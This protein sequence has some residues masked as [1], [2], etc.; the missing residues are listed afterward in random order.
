M[1]AHAL[2]RRQALLSAG[3]L[4]ALGAAG[5]AGRTS[6]LAPVEASYPRLQ[7]LIDR[8]V[9]EGRLAG[10]TL[11]VKTRGAAL[12]YQT[13]GRLALDA[14]ARADADSLYR[15]YSMTKPVTGLAAMILIEEGRLRL[16]Q[17]IS[18][19]LPDFRA[20]RVLTDAASGATR[21]AENAITVRHLLTHTS[22]LS[23]NINAGDPV[24]ELYRRAGLFAGGRTR[25]PRPGDGAEPATL[26][27][28][29]A[30]LAAMP[31]AFEP[32][33]EWRYSVGLD[34]M[35]LIIERVSGMPFEQFLYRRLF[36]PL[37]MTDTAFYA[38]G[39]R[40][41]RLTTNYFVQNGALTPVDDRARSP[42]ANPEG[43]AYG[44]AGLI[45]SA[46]DYARFCEM[47]LNQGALEGAR[48]LSRETMRIATS[49]LLPPGAA[50]TPALQGGDIGA[51][52]GIA[53]AS[54]VRPGQEPPGALGWGGA[55]GT[56]MWVDPANQAYV[57]FM[58]QFMPSNAYPIWSELRTAAYADFAALP[59]VRR[60]PINISDRPRRNY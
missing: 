36:T 20:M 60:T 22:G 14:E 38:P 8:Y 2:S 19:I 54:S 21:P 29:G 12:R 24:A 49:N 1:H 16:D 7:A 25:I 28:F 40:V 41:N 9:S 23:Y 55:A 47:I 18:D 31:L 27:E 59:E 51:A 6:S 43:V 3:A 46:R 34:L 17:P 5:C 10:A 53:T 15:I 11:A 44:G 30:R 4:A 33:A 39:D 56:T 52:I 42:F 26:A 45:S 35:G 50:R 58:T 37:R 13:A 57:V 48:V 32:G